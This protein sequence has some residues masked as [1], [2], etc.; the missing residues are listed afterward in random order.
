MGRTVLFVVGLWGVFAFTESHPG[1]SGASAQ[2]KSPA[3]LPETPGQDA[4]ALP[5][6]L[7]ADPKSKVT[8]LSRNGTLF[9]EVL[10]GDKARRVHVVAEVCMLQ[11]PLECLLCK[12]GTKEHESIVRTEMDAYLIHAALIAAGAKPGTPVQFVNPKTLEADYKPAT[13]DKIKVTVH[14]S[15]GGKIHTHP[16]QEWIW[17]FKAKQA[18]EYDWVFAGSRFIKDP[19][20][21]ND[22]PYY[23]ANSGEIIS[24]SNSPDATLD[25]PVEISKDDAQL[26][27]EVKTDRVPPLLSK[28]WLILEPHKN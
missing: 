12:K 27:Y 21:P 20:R 17:N 7:Q 13:G 8:P 26:S 23:T 5:P 28:V 16:A 3:N 14:Y 24:I 25:L 19:D 22:P 2:D 1:R 18:M 15:K 9:L 10:P 11:G 4:E 6:L